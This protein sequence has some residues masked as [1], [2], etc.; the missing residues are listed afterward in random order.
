LVAWFQ[1]RRKTWFREPLRFIVF[2]F[3]KT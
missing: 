1:I 2:S 3:V